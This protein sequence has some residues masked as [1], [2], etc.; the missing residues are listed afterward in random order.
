MLI[1]SIINIDEIQ[2]LDSSDRTR[3]WISILTSAAD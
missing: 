1:V 3:T 2:M